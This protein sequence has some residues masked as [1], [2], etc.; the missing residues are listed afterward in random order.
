MYFET[1]LSSWNWNS[2]SRVDGKWVDVAA[3]AAELKGRQN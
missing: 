1:V 3:Q 2:S